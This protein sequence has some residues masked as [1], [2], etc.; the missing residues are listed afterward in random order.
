MKSINPATGELIREH[1]EYSDT[2]VAERMARAEQA[3]AG[4]QRTSFAERGTPMKRAA[5]ILREER[6]AYARLMTAEMG[7]TIASAEAEIDKCA[8][9]CEFYA[10]HAER[11]LA[12]VI[13]PTDA[14]KALS[15]M[16]RWAS[17]G[18]NALE[19]SVLAVLPF[20][21]SGAHGGQCGAI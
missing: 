1:V 12:D 6:A 2:E 11:F 13:V 9:G 16:S 8:W 5:A 3:F 10:E 18:R 17:V 21:R 20:W 4:W 7:K 19:L 15:A 14:Q